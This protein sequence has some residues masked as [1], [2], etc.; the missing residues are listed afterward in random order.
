MGYISVQVQPILL[1]G[2]IPRSGGANPGYSAG[3][4]C[5]WRTE[6]DRYLIWYRKRFTILLL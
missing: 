5:W 6:A 1:D 4:L 2:P 3:V